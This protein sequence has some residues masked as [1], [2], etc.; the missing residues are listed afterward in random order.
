MPPGG[1]RTHDLSRRAAAEFGVIYSSAKLLDAARMLLNI[2][3]QA[4]FCATFYIYSKVQNF[5][6][7][8]LR[9]W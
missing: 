9:L 3:R 1:I 4:T 8:E 6:W 5:S 7:T 2:E